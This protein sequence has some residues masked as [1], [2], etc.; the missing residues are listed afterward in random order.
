MDSFAKILYSFFFYQKLL[1]RWAETIAIFY[2]FLKVKLK[3]Q[4]NRFYSLL[5]TG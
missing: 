2:W 5:M 1:K 4:I 3:F